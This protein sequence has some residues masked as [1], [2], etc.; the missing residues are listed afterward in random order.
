MLFRSDAKSGTAPIYEINPFKAATSTSDTVKNSYTTI[1]AASSDEGLVTE[2]DDGGDH[3]YYGAVFFDL[4]G[5]L[6]AIDNTTGEIYKITL[7]DTYVAELYSKG[8]IS[9]NNDGARCMFAPVGVDNPPL[10]IYKETLNYAVT[11][12]S[13]ITYTIV[14]YN[15]S[16]LPHNDA[17]I[18]DIIPNGVTYVS[19]SLKVNGETYDGN[20][21]DGIT[22]A[23]VPAGATDYITFEVLVNSDN[24]TVKTVVNRATVSA[25]QMGTTTSNTTSTQIIRP[26]RGIEFI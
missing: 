17:I 26:Y 24:T 14:V 13:V 9:T 4:Y 22:I 2:T 19:G 3:V 1:D 15:P 8:Q 7:G 12:G 20:I 11:V 21:E 6:Y 10:E 23:S 5:Y 18:T 25:N 16:T